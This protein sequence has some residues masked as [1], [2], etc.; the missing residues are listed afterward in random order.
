MQSKEPLTN[1]PILLSNI[2]VTTSANIISRF[3]ATTAF[4]TFG[5]SR[6]APSLLPLQLRVRTRLYDQERNNS[7]PSLRWESIP[8][9]ESRQEL[10]EKDYMFTRQVALC[11]GAIKIVEDKAAKIEA[12]RDQASK[13]KAVEDKAVRDP[14]RQSTG[15]IQRRPPV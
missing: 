8:C 1:M 10:D 2:I 9:R 5:E 14:S 12:A 7:S 3:P 15:T 6:Y 13:G 11:S 4:D